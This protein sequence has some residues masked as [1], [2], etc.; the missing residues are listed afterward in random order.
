M[1]RTKKPRPGSPVAEDQVEDLVDRLEAA[2]AD[3][4]VD[5]LDDDG[6]ADGLCLT[7][8]EFRSLLGILFPTAFPADPPAANRPTGT[9]P[10]TPARAA[11]YRR[12]LLAA[13]AVFLGGDH[14]TQDDDRTLLT[15]DASGSRGEWVGPLP[16][17]DWAEPSNSVRT[18]RPRRGAV[19]TEHGRDLPD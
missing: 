3:G 11:V 9:R 6:P 1:T 19:R 16:G 12:R 2:V 7:L 10:G 14:A 17:N 5:L 13:R 15:R 18:G 8:S 4:R